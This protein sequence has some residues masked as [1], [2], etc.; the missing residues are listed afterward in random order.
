L[1]ERLAE[2][3]E[4]DWTYIGRLRLEREKKLRDRKMC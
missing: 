1:V 4:S 2:R 3:E